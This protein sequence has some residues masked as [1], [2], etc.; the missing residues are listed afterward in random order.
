MWAAVS[1]AVRVPGPG[2]AFGTTAVDAAALDVG[3]GI[4]EAFAPA[5]EPVRQTPPVRPSGTARGRA[6]T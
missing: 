4:D 2:A 3:S 6:P 1:E 5:S